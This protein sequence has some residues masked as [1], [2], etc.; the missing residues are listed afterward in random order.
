MFEMQKKKKVFYHFI[1]NLERSSCSSSSFDLEER[2]I[3]VPTILSPLF[4]FRSL[5]FVHLHVFLFNIEASSSAF[6]KFGSHC[7]V[8]SSDKLPG[9]SLV[10][11][12]AI[13][14]S[15]TV[16]VSIYDISSWSEYEIKIMRSVNGVVDVRRAWKHH[17]TIRKNLRQSVMLWAAFDVQF[18]HGVPDHLRSSLIVRQ[19]YRLVKNDALRLNT[20]GLHRNLDDVK[21]W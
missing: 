6:S 8:L 16:V 13:L 15:R 19:H 12:I 5:L 3:M 1:K 4:K 10:I 14:I 7:H 21:V 11:E 2:S 18:E 9:L 20:F 17:F